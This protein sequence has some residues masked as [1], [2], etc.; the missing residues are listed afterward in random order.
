MATATARTV[1]LDR[2]LPLA[3]GGA[4]GAVAARLGLP[5]AP[6]LIGVGVLL[7]VASGYSSAW[8]P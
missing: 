7:A 4:C 6:S 3:L 8:S 2:L 5:S 1:T